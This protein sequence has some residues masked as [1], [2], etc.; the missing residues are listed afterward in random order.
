MQPPAVKKSSTILSPHIE[1]LEGGSMFIEFDNMER[2]HPLD[3]RLTGKVKVYL[4]QPFM[5]ANL[6]LCIDGFARSQF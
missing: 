1:V 6:T 2:A 4:T 5:P 3:S